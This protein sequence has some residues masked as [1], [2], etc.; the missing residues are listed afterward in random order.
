MEQDTLILTEVLSA[1]NVK[2]KVDVSHWDKW[3][4]NLSQ[5]DEPKYKP[6][7]K[8]DLQTVQF[9]STKPQNWLCYSCWWKTMRLEGC[10]QNNHGLTTQRVNF[11]RQQIPLD[12]SLWEN[13]C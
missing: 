11:K 10:F 1:C 8:I 3:E 7:S 4:D 13:V 5:Q 12:G 2:Q 9:Q 6:Q